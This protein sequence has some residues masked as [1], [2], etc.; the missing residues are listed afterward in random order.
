LDEDGGGI[1]EKELRPVEPITEPLTLASLMHSWKDEN[2]SSSFVGGPFDEM[3]DEGDTFMPFLG[4]YD[5]IKESSSDED[6]AVFKATDCPL[7]IIIS[8]IFWLA[9]EVLPELLVRPMAPTEWVD[10][11]VNEDVRFKGVRADR[12]EEGIDLEEGYN[13]P[14]TTDAAVVE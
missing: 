12:V 5:F 11:D 3:D 6:K 4:L 10:V 9:V 1:T 7:W 8:C 14:A 2:F 13:P